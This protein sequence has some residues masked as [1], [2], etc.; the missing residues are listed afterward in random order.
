MLKQVAELWL[1]LGL[2][3]GF[4]KCLHN[5]WILSNAKGEERSREGVIG[6]AVCGESGVKLQGSKRF[7][8]RQYSRAE[9]A[10][11]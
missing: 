6:S 8:Q 5:P 3:L 2:N 4:S 9:L 7:P 1:N 10:G 11:K